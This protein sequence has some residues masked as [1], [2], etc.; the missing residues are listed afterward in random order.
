MRAPGSGGNRKAL[1]VSAVTGEGLPSLL[2]T[3]ERFLEDRF[4]TME[5]LIPFNRYDMISQLHQLGNVQKE[6]AKEEGVHIVA[7]LPERIKTQYA[8]FSVV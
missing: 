8:V 2:E 4:V 3:C 5:L 7:T 1:Y 6:K